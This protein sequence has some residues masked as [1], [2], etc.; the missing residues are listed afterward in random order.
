MQR[1]PQRRAV[2]ELGIADDAVKADGSSPEIADLR[3]PL[4]IGVFVH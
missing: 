1:R 3:C 2:A 4:F